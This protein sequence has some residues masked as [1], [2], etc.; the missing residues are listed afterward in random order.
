[1]PTPQALE[2]LRRATERMKAAQQ[3]H[4][5]FIERPDRQFS[6]EERAEDRRLLDKVNRSTAAYWEA[7]EKASTLG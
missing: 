6:P 4:L 3:A 1:M 7:F 2:N 5:A